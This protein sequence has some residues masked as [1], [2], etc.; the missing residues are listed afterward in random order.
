[1]TFVIRG[2]WMGLALA[3]GAGL[4]PL[5]AQQPG[6]GGAGPVRIAFVNARTILQGMPGYAQAESTFTKEL[7]GSRA[8]LARL[9]ASLDSAVADFQQ[10]SPMLSSA[11][12]AAKQKELEAKNQQLQQRNQE[13]Q[14]GLDQRQQELVGPIQQRLTGIIEGIRAEGNY[15]MIID[16]GAEGLGIVTYDKSLDLTARVIQRLRQTN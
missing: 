6:G 1:M 11:T 13:I 10:Q 5:M 4:G 12:R 9:Q 16:L 8:E 3:G 7:E 14:Q 15:A 2:W